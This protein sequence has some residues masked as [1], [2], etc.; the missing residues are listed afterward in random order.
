MS[1]WIWDDQSS[2]SKESKQLFLKK[3]I[4][5]KKLILSKLRE[6]RFSRVWKENGSKQKE[7]AALLQDGL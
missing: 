2:N 3:L 7:Q 4:L 6:R 5:R 1:V